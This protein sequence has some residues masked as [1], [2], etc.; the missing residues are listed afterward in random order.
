[1]LHATALT[2]EHP[3]TGAVLEAAVPVPDDMA[4]VI[5]SLGPAVS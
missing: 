3:V 5:A 2:L 1:M 4:A